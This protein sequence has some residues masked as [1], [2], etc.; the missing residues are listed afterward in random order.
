MRVGEDTVV[1]VI[2]LSEVG[3]DVVS[4]NIEKVGTRVGLKL[5]G[6]TG[7]LENAAQLSPFPGIIVGGPAIAVGVN[8]GVALG[9]G[10]GLELGLSLGL[11]VDATLGTALGLGLGLAVGLELGLALG[12]L[13]GCTVGIELGRLDV[14][15]RVG[16]TVE[17]KVGRL[18]GLATGIIVIKVIGLLVGIFVLLGI[19]LLLLTGL[20][21][22]LFITEVVSSVLETCLFLTGLEV[23]LLV[24]TVVSSVLATGLLLLTGLEVGLL[25]MEVVSSVLATGLLLKV[26]PLVESSVLKT[27][28]L[29]TGCFFIDGLGFGVGITAKEPSSV[30]EL[31]GESSVL[32]LD[33][34][35]EGFDLLLVPFVFPLEPLKFVGCFATGPGRQFP[36]LPP[37]FF[38]NQSRPLF[39]ALSA[40]CLVT[41]FTLFASVSKIFEHG[42]L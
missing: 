3:L 30:L 25:I 27:G 42:L 29:L 35:V 19:F 32:K 38:F 24:T 4:V 31:F 17:I 36:V 28:C 11:G 33:P 7:A 13:V 9:L 39:T 16:P 1:V 10:D 18:V 8:V 20:E 23:G 2:V 5:V 26:G 22:G 40:T 12:I 21:V 34:G 37:T 6:E 14:G 41:L 15:A